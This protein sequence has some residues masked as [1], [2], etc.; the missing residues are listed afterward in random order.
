M[1]E[2]LQ[3]ILSRA[4]I[5][6]RR[7]A[8]AM[9]LDGRVTVNGEIARELGVKADLDSDHIKVDGKL[10][11]PP[12]Q[13]VYVMLNKPR[14]YVTTMFDPEGRPKVVDLLRAVKERVYPVGRLD[15]H[16]EGL[17]LLT[18]DGDF[19]NLIM[20]ASSEVPKT[21]WVKVAGQPAE[22]K[23]E[24]L[25][26]GVKLEGRLT[27]PARIRLL[28]E[29]ANPWYEMTLTEGRQNQIR[30]MFAR[31]GHM[32]EKLKRVRIGFLELRDLPPGQYRRLTSQEV[33]R[34]R[35]MQPGR[36]AS[37]RSSA[38]PAARPAWTRTQTP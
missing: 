37:A 23:I 5:A 7:K 21:Y 31:V 33:D 36:A 13:T 1:Q 38:A 17:L 14:G 19:A 25:R 28:R 35:R 12:K 11:R 6:S 26:R 9:I 4:G 2:R 30:R 20:K 16:S 8:E 29:G 27:A 15:F 24:R 3:K 10:V 32:V 22:E 34:F 18:N